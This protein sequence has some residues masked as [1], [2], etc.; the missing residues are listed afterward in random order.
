[1]GNVPQW[2]AVS[3]GHSGGCVIWTQ[4]GPLR[5]ATLS[6]MGAGRRGTYYS[7]TV[8]RARPITTLADQPL[9]VLG[10]VRITLPYPG[11]SP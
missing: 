7:S 4:Q 6:A 5:S 11:S 9:P 10:R 1:M 3:I 8:R 2:L